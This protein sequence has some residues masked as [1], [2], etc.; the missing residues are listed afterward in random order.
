MRSSVARSSGL[1]AALVAVLMVSAGTAGAATVSVQ[2][3]KLSY[4]A[5]AGESNDVTLIRHLVS[6]YGANRIGRQYAPSQF[7]HL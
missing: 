7:K 3:S 2:G 4:F 1:V 6:R 5:A